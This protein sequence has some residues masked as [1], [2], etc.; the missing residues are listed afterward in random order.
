MSKITTLFK[1]YKCGDLCPSHECAN[2]ECW[3][4]LINLDKS[5]SSAMNHCGRKGGSKQKK[6]VLDLSHS[7]CWSLMFWYMPL[8]NLGKYIPA[9]WGL[10]ILSS[11][12]GPTVYYG[13]VQVL[14]FILGVV[15]HLSQT[16][17]GIARNV[18]SALSIWGWGLHSCDI[19][20]WQKSRCHLK[21][22]FENTDHPSTNLKVTGLIPW[23][24]QLHVKVPLS[25]ILTP[26]LL[27]MSRS[28]PLSSVCN[29]DK[30]CKKNKGK[31]AMEMQFHLHITYAAPRHA[32][33]IQKKQT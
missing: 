4:S 3:G 19:I 16:W 6:K 2:H 8:I 33:I 18:P 1:D 29:C 13:H 25:K 11:I 15:C 22:Q 30:C 27:L 32:I 21:T 9:E 28:A 23:I 20:T 17:V 31:S 10:W 14:T 24:P 7:V 12:T 5:D 26:K